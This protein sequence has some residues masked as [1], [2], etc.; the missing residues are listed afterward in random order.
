MLFR[1]QRRRMY[2][3][4][5]DVF[6]FDIVPERYGKSISCK[7]RKIGRI[8]VYTAYA[9]ACPHYIIC[10]YGAEPAAGVRQQYAVA[11]VG[12]A[13]DIYHCGIGHDCILQYGYRDAA[14]LAPLIYW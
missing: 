11:C 5:A 6:Q 13:E 9:S 4:I 3:Y 1:E 14:A 2:L 7:M 10:E 8:A 12:A